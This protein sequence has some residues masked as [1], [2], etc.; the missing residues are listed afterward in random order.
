MNGLL[1]YL[2]AFILGANVISIYPVYFLN[3]Y[4]QQS[5]NRAQ[6]GNDNKERINV[7][8]LLMQIAVMFGI[9]N[10]IIYLLKTTLLKGFDLW[11]L[12][13]I[14]GFILG[15]YGSYLGRF[16]VQIPKFLVNLSPES[17]WIVHVYVPIFYSL[18]FATIVYFFNISYLY[19]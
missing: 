18:I 14:V 9:S 16:N 10:V 17:E 7:T 4:L 6:I 15:I 8:T 5:R 1:N 13:V 12:H 11:W 19:K 3:D 2:L